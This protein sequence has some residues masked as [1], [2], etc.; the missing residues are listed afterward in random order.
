M[1][2]GQSANA[3]QATLSQSLSA[4]GS[5]TT[6]YLSKIT[7]LT[8]ETLST[9]DFAT[10]GKGTVT[11]DPLSST[12]IEFVS[13]TA[14]DSTNIA[15]T[16]AAR[17]LSAFDYTASTSRAK[18]HPVGTKIIISFGSHNLLDL[19]TYIQGLVAGTIGNASASATG[20]TKLSTAPV[21][22]TIP[23]AVGDNDT[24]IATATQT[25]YLAAVSQLGLW[26]AADSVGTDAYS[27]TLSPAPGAYANGMTVSFKAG[28]ANTGAATLKINSL[29]AITIKK[30]YNA[31]LATGDI[32][33]NQI[34]QIVY[35]GTN[36]QVQ[37]P[38]S[39][40][41]LVNTGATTKDISSTTTTTIA[42]G[43]GIAP[44]IVRVYGAFGN[45]TNSSSCRA[46]WTSG[47]GLV[48]NTTNTKITATTTSEGVATFRLRSNWTPSSEDYLEINT[49]TVDAT[50]ISITWTKTN[51]PSGTAQLA[52]DAE[53]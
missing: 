2:V 17:G 24:R 20:V 10:F 21:S 6:I 19:I 41:I 46:S 5:E 1:A 12:N 35:D 34:V 28:T 8:G 16:G 30:N 47:G 4:G 26:Y 31:D 25:A 39:N 13:F 52:W 11:I 43:L 48:A 49:L 18:Y 7:T 15:F 53:A 3:F 23:I 9:A 38:L 27:I 37:S 22:P 44:K 36:W 40:S 32:L 50:N 33:Q 45:G 42:H 29:A 14:V 51:S